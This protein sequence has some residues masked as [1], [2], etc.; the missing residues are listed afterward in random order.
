MIGGG[1]GGIIS[2]VAFKSSE[3]PRYDVGR[4]AASSA[5]VIRLTIQSDGH[6]D[7][8][9]LLNRKRQLDRHHVAALLSVQYRSPC[10]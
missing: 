4:V 10:R 2:G 9:R 6:M 5:S 3:S 1:L 7:H 8:S